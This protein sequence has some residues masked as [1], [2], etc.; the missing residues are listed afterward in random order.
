[1][2]EKIFIVPQT[3]NRGKNIKA[4]TTSE[5]GTSKKN[6][7]YN[8]HTQPTCKLP[9]KISNINSNQVQFVKNRYDFSNYKQTPTFESAVTTTQA[10]KHIISSN[11]VNK[12]HPSFE[13]FQTGSSLV[14]S[15]TQNAIAEVTTNTLDVTPN[16]TMSMSSLSTPPSLVINTMQLPSIY[17]TIPDVSNSWSSTQA[18]NLFSHKRTM[19]LLDSFV[20]TD[21]FHK[22]VFISNPSLIAFSTKAQSLCQFVCHHLSVPNNHQERF[23]SLYNK[24]VEKKLNQKRADVSNAIKKNFMGKFK[25]E[26]YLS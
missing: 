15:N 4:S 11:P 7:T 24:Y 13:L 23:W 6:E 25:Q 26:F 19:R 8:P 12:G 17:R 1:M 16:T 21:I 18:D 14:Q 9:V 20:K 22:I 10:E 2:A 3:S 5:T